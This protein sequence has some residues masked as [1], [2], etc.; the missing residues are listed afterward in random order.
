MYFNENQS[1]EIC[2][3]NRGNPLNR[4]CLNRGFTLFVLCI[5][6]LEIDL[7]FTVHHGA[8]S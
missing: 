8:F 4:D 2:S 7:L 1:A 6:D 5:C 3:L